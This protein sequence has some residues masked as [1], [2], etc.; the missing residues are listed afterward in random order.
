[1]VLLVGLG[2]PAAL[3][4]ETAGADPAYDLSAVDARLR[5]ATDGCAEECDIWFRLTREG[6]GGPGDDDQLMDRRYGT[7]AAPNGTWWTASAGKLLSGVVIMSVVDDGLLSLDT[8]VEDLLPDHAGTPK[9]S[10]TVRQLMS[11]SS[12]LPGLNEGFVADP[13]ENDDTVTLQACVTTILDEVDLVYAPGAGFAY[14]GTSMEVAG[15]L[16]ELA[17]GKTWRQLWADNIAGPL[18]L[19]E[20][21]GWSTDNPALG[22]GSAPNGS[23]APVGDYDRVLEMLQHHGDFRGTRVLSEAAVDAMVTNHVE[24]L[25]IVYTPAPGAVGYGIGGWVEA[26][27]G[28]GATTR[29][30]S[31]GLFGTLPWVDFELG[32][33]GLMAMMSSGAVRNAIWADIQPV[34]ESQIA[35]NPVGTPPPPPTPFPAVGDLGPDVGTV[36]GGEPIV[37]TGTGFTGAYAVHFGTGRLSPSFTVDSDTQITAIAAPRTPAG[38][39]NVRV[40][41]P[42]GTSLIGPPAYYRYVDAVVPD[43]DAVTPTGG[44]EVGGQVVTITGTGFTSASM[45]E[46]GAGN[47]APSFTVDSATQITATVPPHAPALVNV[48]VTAPGGRSAAQAWESWYRYTAD[49]PPPAV[50]AVSPSSGPAAGGGTVT[51]TGSG[52]TGATAVEFGA[53]SPSS[54]TVVSD[55][56]ITAVAPPRS[57]ALVNVF[58][59]TPVGRSPSVPWQTFYTYR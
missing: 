9:G 55:S 23:R 12:G 45:V 51:I 5:A 40:Q 1:M 6:P 47:P 4:P 57:P 46:L 48:F 10:M 13:C 41:T 38:L 53:G 8:S 25:P 44:S 32:Y 15:A 22:G 52:F 7:K 20:L 58:V 21:T 3:V 11:H 14:G 43:V 50:T 36:L 31:P 49:G 33:R 16:A 56:T 18:G 37:I 39:V 59:T 35:A 28:T 17:T 2:L 24:G 19:S 34:I 30:S 54:F 29:F 26:V 27:D 42:G